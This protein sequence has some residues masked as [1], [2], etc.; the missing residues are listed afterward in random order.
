MLKKALVYTFA[1]VHT[2]VCIV[3]GGCG[4]VSIAS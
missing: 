1:K 3:G 4:G 2:S